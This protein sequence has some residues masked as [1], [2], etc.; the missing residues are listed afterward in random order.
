[1][2]SKVF[3]IVFLSI[4]INLQSFGVNYGDNLKVK[5]D[6]V[7]NSINADRSLNPLNIDTAKDDFIVESID[8]LGY[9]Y[10]CPIVHEGFS[11]EM[12]ILNINS[13]TLVILNILLDNFEGRFTERI[14]LFKFSN[15]NLTIIDQSVVKDYLVKHLPPCFGI[16]EDK[17]Q[18]KYCIGINSFWIFTLKDEFVV[19]L[20]EDSLMQYDE[21]ITCDYILKCNKS[22]KIDLKTFFHANN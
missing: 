1:M 18:S 15:G 5:I 13:D 10:V 16:L 2:K 17:L 4:V 9:Y 3:C 20:N 6:S 12:K 7:L 19:K 21:I 22:H 11:C 14:N 8:S